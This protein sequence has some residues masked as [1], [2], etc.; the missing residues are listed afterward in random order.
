MA[1]YLL[2]LGRKNRGLFFPEWSSASLSP[3]QPGSSGADY[4]LSCEKVNT[5]VGS[6]ISGSDTKRSAC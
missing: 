5:Y 1:E 4:Q 3:R 2:E 6:K